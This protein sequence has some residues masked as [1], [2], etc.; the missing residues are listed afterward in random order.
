MIRLM[1]EQQA[2][3]ADARGC[4]GSGLSAPSYRSAT[5]SSQL[6]NRKFEFV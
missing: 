3:Y 2:S 6:I 1:R 4:Y 5:E